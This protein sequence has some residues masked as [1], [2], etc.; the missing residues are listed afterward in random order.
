[1]S[2]P[3][4]RRDFLG[5]AAGA[6]V[7]PAAAASAIAGRPSSRLL[8]M[9]GYATDAE[10]PLDLRADYRTPNDVFFVRHHW[11]PK[12]PDLAA[13]KLRVEG[14]VSTPLELACRKLGRLPAANATRAPVPATAALRRAGRS[15]RPWNGAVETRADRREG[16]G[17]AGKPD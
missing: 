15:R 11:I 17:R 9:N 10:S 8:Q 14:D 13:G 12:M 3:I 2:S 4:S 1:M 6:A 5:V 16:P 7:F